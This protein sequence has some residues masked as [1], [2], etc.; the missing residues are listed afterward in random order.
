MKWTEQP[1]GAEPGRLGEFVRGRSLVAALPLLATLAKSSQ[2]R[3]HRRCRAGIAAHVAMRNLELGG[4]LLGRA[5]RPDPEL[6]SGWGAVVEV[7]DFVPAVECES[8]GVSLVMGAG[9]WS[10]AHARLSDGL[11]VVGWYHSHPDLGAFFSGTDR[12][13]QRGFFTQPHQL[14]LV[15]DPVRGEEAWFLGPDSRPLAPDAVV[16]V[17]ADP[18]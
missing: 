10:R 1:G 18:G 7:E 17:E 13:T 3:V 4:L 12:R 11:Q 6:P 16:L 9:L 14:G 15:T 5:W 2:V 8:T